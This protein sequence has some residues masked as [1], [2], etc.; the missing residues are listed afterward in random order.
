M[1]GTHPNRMQPRDE[2]AH[3][4]IQDAIDKGYLDSGRKYIIMGFPTHDR[5][6]EARLSILRGLNHFGLSP[7]AWVTDS[8]E[9]QCYRDCKDPNAVH[10]AGFELHSKNEGRKH[11]VRETGGDPSKLK[12][13]PHMTRRQGRF[14]PD[15]TW[16]PGT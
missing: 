12:W 11:V 14:S 10:G 13:N 5:A 15:G 3:G 9:T 8:G 6:N 2:R 4:Y 1:A 16:Q 7:A